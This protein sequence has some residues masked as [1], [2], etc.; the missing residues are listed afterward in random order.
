MELHH[1]SPH[2]LAL[3]ENAAWVKRLARSLIADAHL[4]EDVAQDALA[5]A[6]ERP[7][8]FADNAERL[9]RWLGGVTRHLAIRVRRREGE[10]ETREAQAARQAATGDGGSDE[11]L[12]LHHR[13][14]EAVLGLDE[15]YR[16]TVV[17][18]FFDEVPPRE[19]ARRQGIAAASVRK[20][21]SRAMLMLRTRLDRDFEGGRGA[22]CV[23]LVGLVEAGAESASAV[24][25]T[26]AMPVA[27]AVILLVFTFVGWRGWNARGGGSGALDV[28]TTLEP[29]TPS[30]RQADRVA[31]APVGSGAARSGIESDARAPTARLEV[32]VLDEEGGAL[33]RAQ[34]HLVSSGELLESGTTDSDGRVLFEARDLAG[35]VIAQ[36]PGRPPRLRS[37]ERLDGRCELVLGAGASLS[38]WL[39]EDGDAPREPLRLSLGS[40][41]DPLGALDEEVQELLSRA[42]VRL[43]KREVALSAD[44][45]FRFIGLPSDWSGWVGLP[46]THWFVE[47][48]PGGNLRGSGES[49]GLDSPAQGLA[50]PTTRLPMIRGRI[51][52]AQSGAPLSGVGLVI[53][54]HFDDDSMTPGIGMQADGEGRFVLGLVDSSP[55]R[56]LFLRDPANRPAISKVSVSVSGQG[57]CLG[58]YVVFL[59]DEIGPD[60]DIG[61]ILLPRGLA[62]HILVRDEAGEPIPGA[63]ASAGATSGP[64]DAQ[65]RTRL[66]GIA[67]DR[68]HML[69]GAPTHRIQRVAIGAGGRSAQDP[70]EV[71][72]L[73][74]NRLEL[75]VICT[76]AS[77]ALGLRIRIE[78]QGRLFEIG[79]AGR[80][81]YLNNKFESSRMASSLWSEEGGWTFFPLDAEGRL[82]LLN[83][84]PAAEFEVEVRSGSTPLLRKRLQGPGYG[85]TVRHELVVTEQPFDLELTVRDGSGQPLPR[86][87]LVLRSASGWFRTRT[88][89]SGLGRFAQIFALP[90]TASLEATCTGHAPVFVEGILLGPRAQLPDLVL[91]RGREIE[92]RVIDESGATV[93]VDGATARAPGH[94]RMQGH[95]REQGLV[96]L[97]DLPLGRVEL[98]VSYGL[99]TYAIEHDT[100]QAHATLVVPVHGELVLELSPECAAATDHWFSGKLTSRPDMDVDTEIGFDDEDGRQEFRRPLVPGHYRVQLLLHRGGDGEFLSEP[101][102]SQ[103]MFEVRAGEVTRLTLGG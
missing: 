73:Q 62:L 87:S 99:R 41:Q 68:D 9:R 47:A 65:G 103:R 67:A 59:P 12:Q 52:D 6:L 90:E 34:V 70:I 54:A 46:S 2:E 3:L 48:P 81:S 60:G 85:E 22:W 44:G 19:M 64:T 80:G 50:L 86:V 14:V 24:V 89:E 25:L 79:Y 33:E 38:G 97:T 56:H 29:E 98:S 57:E 11:R 21:L 77:A 82:T 100:L 18:R 94:P 49:L 72:L 71:V 37:L 10:R 4:A 7:P 55:S 30:G 93:P 5:A 69:V 74:G 45:S 61:D 16:S 92:L 36:A 96:L 23:A 39:T 26:K 43:A 15:P 88:D 76:P 31:V 32:H 91:E 17:M 27:V 101:F 78:V 20:R 13:L 35:H 8:G 40:Y 28:S 83:L 75:A 58:T 66:G 63:L 1:E 42:G 51:L 95:V 102:G 53:E 84:A